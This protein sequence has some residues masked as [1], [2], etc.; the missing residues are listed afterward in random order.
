MKSKVYTSTAV[1]FSPKI[2]NLTPRQFKMYYEMLC[3]ADSDGF[4]PNIKLV[5]G[6]TKKDIEKFI[7]VGAILEAGE[8][9][10][11]ADWWVHNKKD[12]H[13]YTE[14]AYTSLLSKFS[15]NEKGAYYAVSEG[16]KSLQVDSKYSV[17]ESK[18]K[19]SKGKESK[20]V[21]QPLP[22]NDPEETETVFKKGDYEKVHLYN[23]VVDFA[24]DE[25]IQTSEK[26]VRKFIRYNLDKNKEVFSYPDRWRANFR[27]WAELEKD[28][29]AIV[30]S[31]HF[32]HLGG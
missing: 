12:K 28:P 9:Y 14:G 30:G 25:H 29:T 26:S 18:V 20:V 13:H 21:S 1:M 19:E 4:L 10:L 15:L 5:R 31:E 32:N 27:K 8:V 17:V 22:F 16:E 2:D 7:E 23:M 11:I 24:R 3:Q 6:I